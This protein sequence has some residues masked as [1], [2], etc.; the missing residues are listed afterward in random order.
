MKE[1]AQSITDE[2]EAN[3]AQSN[4]YA[5]QI[6]MLQEALARGDVQG[7]AEQWKEFNS[8]I[9]NGLQN[10]YPMLVQELAAIASQEGNVE[11]HTAA[12]ARELKNAQKQANAKYFKD[13]A[14]ALN[15]L[16]T[17][18]KSATQVA[19][20]F[21]DEEE[22]VT[23]AQLEY[24]EATQKK[25]KGIE[26][27][28]DEVKKLADVLGWTPESLLK[29]W[30]MVQPMLDELT[31]S[32]ENMRNEMQKEIYLNITGTSEADFS[33]VLNG[34]AVVQ[35]EADAAVQ[36]LLATGQF[37]LDTEE[38][39]QTMRYPVLNGGMFDGVHYET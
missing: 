37:E 27:T 33:N 25:A 32:M 15:D 14:K 19:K 21:R 6:T 2:V 22:K 30:D 11:D 4:G 8:T 31:A 29:N 10:T 9:Q 39:K 34:L 36:A 20:A 13:T 23:E 16:R 7:A 1:L 17:G 3:R 18:T 38:L 5:E 28:A 24:L 26:V 35:N 12:L